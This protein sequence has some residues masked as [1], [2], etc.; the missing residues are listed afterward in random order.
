M[1]PQTYNGGVDY[2]RLLG[3]GGMRR[4]IFAVST[5]EFYYDAYRG[6]WRLESGDGGHLY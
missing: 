4:R 6:M 3:K 5:T 1:M 2:C